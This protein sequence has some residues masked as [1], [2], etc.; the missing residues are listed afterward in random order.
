MEK[1]FFKIGVIDIKWY[2]VII[3]LGIFIGSLLLIKESKKYNFSTELILDMILGMIICSIIGARI[4]YV[5]FEWP[6]Y[7]LFPSEILKIWHGGLAIHG[8][9]IGGLLW[10]I[11]FTKKQKWNIFKITDIIVVSLIIGQSIGRWG[12]FIN[13]E[14][15]GYQ[16]TLEFLQSLN[17][18]NFIIEGMKINGTYFHP[19]FLYESSWCLIGFIVLLLIRKFMKVRTGQ[20]TGIYFIWYGFGRLIIEQMR[21]DSLLIGNFKIAQIISLIMILIGLILIIYKKKAKLYKE[22]Y[23]E[24]KL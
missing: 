13:G 19:T 24:K 14:A 3:L 6:Y 1:T 7:S 20:L 15:H 21:T 17:L 2:A 23:N 10:L 9:I 12:N 22:E 16:T 4:Y 11:Y 5:I 8:G 18:P